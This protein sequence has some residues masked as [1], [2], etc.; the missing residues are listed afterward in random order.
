MAY[1]VLTLWSFACARVLL[2]LEPVA[3]HACDVCLDDLLAL[4][5]HL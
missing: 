4:L 5:I 1:P 3:T 2:N